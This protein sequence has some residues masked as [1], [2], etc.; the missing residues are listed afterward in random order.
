[1]HLDPLA[2]PVS[3]RRFGPWAVDL[4]HGERLARTRSLHAIVRLLS[5]PRGTDLADLL[6]LAETDDAVLPEA[7][8]A[9]D[10][11]APV[12]M[13]RVL[14]SY[15]ALARPLSPALGARPGVR[16]QQLTTPRT[17]TRSTWQAAA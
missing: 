16:A 17:S 11:L 13:R 5:S 3:V 9:L 10:R 15:A 12:D 4:D 7:A 1:M 6:A 2:G 14:S 8:D